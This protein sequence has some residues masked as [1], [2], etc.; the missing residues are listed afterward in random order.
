MMFRLSLISFLFL[1]FGRE[2]AFAQHLHPY[3]DPEEY[4]DLLKMFSLQRDTS[5]ESLR[6]K[7]P[8]DYEMT[9]RSPETGLV[10][11]WD[12]WLNTKKGTGVIAIRGTNG[13]AA[14]WLENLYAGMIPAK[15]VLQLN[16]STHFNYQVAAD[17]QAGVHA[18]WML[19]TAAMVPDMV[20]HILEYYRQG[21]HEF[22][23]AGHSQG[24]AIAFLVRS[25]LY[26]REDL[27]KDLVLKTYCSAAPKPGN[28]A[29]A[30][31]YDFITRDG[32]GLRVVNGRDWVP[33]TPF[34]V[35]TPHD[36]SPVNPFM[37]IRKTIR[38]QKFP[39][40]LALSYTYG[41]L[42]R[43]MKRSS[44]RLQRVLGKIAYSRVK[45][46][47]PAY[48]RPPFINSHHYTPAGAPV[49]LYP[50]TGYDEA[51]PFDGKN[52]FVHHSLTAYR[53]ALEKIYP[54]SISH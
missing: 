1:F 41:R 10:N 31:D 48:S 2:I 19:A 12:F 28:Q 22:I 21:I 23:I 46:L 53:W 9:Y 30:Y 7:A 14:S 44:R 40:N 34:S 47:L 13:T 17:P 42:S 52:I 29:Y 37:N 5:A 50:V 15:G 4:S 33:E 49:I 43:P 35:Q 26:Y 45:K 8:A 51:F 11:R 32:W 24:G 20:E 36:F 3:F 6:Q 38:K 16:D 25:C 18:G 27:P 54:K 39:V